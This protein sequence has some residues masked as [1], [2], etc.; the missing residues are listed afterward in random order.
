MAKPPKQKI[1]APRV[2]NAQL[3]SKFEMLCKAYGVVSR[4]FKSRDITAP[5]D[6]D[7]YDGT[8]QWAMNKTVQGWMIVSGWKGCGVN[9]VRWNGYIRTR[10]DFLM[11]IEALWRSK[12]PKQDNERLVEVKN[13]AQ[14]LIAAGVTT[15]SGACG[16]CGLHNDFH[17]KDCAFEKLRALLEG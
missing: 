14:H 13:A 5:I 2:S 4:G 9:F 10:W 12:P 3:L 16:A 11:F 15:D 17:E 6:G 1:R 8:T 7:K